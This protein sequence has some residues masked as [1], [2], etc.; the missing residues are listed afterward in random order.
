MLGLCDGNR[1]DR[2]HAGSQRRLDWQSAKVVRLMRVTVK[3]SKVLDRL[4]SK[5]VRICRKPMAVLVV[6]DED[7]L[8]GESGKEGQAEGWAGR[9]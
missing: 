6:R 3:G 2:Q 7:D 4:S 9:R 1:I 8:G 5:A